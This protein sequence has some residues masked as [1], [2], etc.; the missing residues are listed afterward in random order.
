MDWVIRGFGL[1]YIVSGAFLVRAMAVDGMASKLEQ[2]VFGQKTKDKVRHVWLRVGA[3]LTVASGLA[4]AVLGVLTIP[5]MVA[6]CIVQGGW[7]I[8]ANSN[9]PPEDEDEALGRKR[10]TN[11]FF[12]FVGVTALTVW[13]FWSGTAELHGG[14]VRAMWVP[15]ATW[16]PAVGGLAV[17]VAMMVA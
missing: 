10:T 13:A 15:V 4:M 12:V 11:A 5:L 7:L 14:A 8:Y 6:N 1:F 17:F 16:L 9:F 2:M 3:A